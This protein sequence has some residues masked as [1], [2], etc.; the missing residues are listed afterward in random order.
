MTTGAK[1]AIASAVGV[2]VGF[3]GGYIC[4]KAVTAKKVEEDI[5]AKE[6]QMDDIYRGL[7]VKHGI[8]ADLMDLDIIAQ[9]SEKELEVKVEQADL[10]KVPEQKPFN[11]GFIV[12]EEDDGP[13]EY[14]PE[15]EDVEYYDES[16][17]EDKETPY[18]ISEDEYGMHPD[19]RFVCC[20]LFYRGPGK[21]Y[22]EEERLVD[23]P[24]Y[25]GYEI[26]KQFDIRREKYIYVRNLAM[27]VDWEIVDDRDP[28]YLTPRNAGSNHD[29][30]KHL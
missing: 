10:P 23:I 2:V 4:C 30:S 24:T 15:G 17:P 6:K 21:V 7:C 8:D 1:I 25:C 5:K 13:V 9:E 19:P 14:T 26:L 27:K 16:D 20:N 11:P 18:E 22:D 28:D 29:E 3:A 12:P